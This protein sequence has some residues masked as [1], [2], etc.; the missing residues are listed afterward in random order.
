[1][2]SLRDQILSEIASALEIDSSLVS[3]ETIASDLEAWD[4]LGHISILVRLDLAFNNVS[5]RFEGLAA[6]TSVIEIIEIISR[7]FT[8]NV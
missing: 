6:A 3:E 8:G 7:D 2:S 4:S 5:E 1:M